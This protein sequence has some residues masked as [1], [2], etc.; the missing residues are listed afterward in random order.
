MLGDRLRRLQAGAGDER[1]DAVV[2][3][4]HA[5]G[6]GGA[7]RADGD[8]DRRLAEDAGE[9]GENDRVVI[10][11]TGTGLKTPQLSE[12]SGTMVEI[13]AD[14]DALLEELGVTA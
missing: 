9:L 7:Q 3:T 14:V 13:D 11:V 4:D 6:R 10:L 12:A 5:R 2:L 8:A 1:D